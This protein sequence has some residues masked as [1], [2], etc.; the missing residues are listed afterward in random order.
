MTA[1]LALGIDPSPQDGMSIQDCV[2]IHCQVVDA[3]N[4]QFLK[5][6]LAFF[7]AH[8]AIGIQLL[9]DFCNR[10]RQS[11]HVIL[12]GKFGEISTSLAAYL[13]FG[14]RL[15][16]SV[17]LNPFLGAQSL[18]D[19][20]QV[21]AKL[22]GKS[23]YV[24]CATSQSSE[25]P[26]AYIQQ[27][28]QKILLACR[29]AGLGVVIGANRVAEMHDATGLDILAPG[30]GAQGASLAALEYAKTV[31]NEIVFPISRGIFAGGNQSVDACVTAYQ[32]WKGKF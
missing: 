2:H 16:Q 6:N 11:H 4:V 3:V 18:D 5:P 10:Y 7:L 17:T 8:G 20:S 31:P 32:M 27:G 24:L 22:N 29:A 21:C 14:F 30:L 25:G 23:V 19:A 1:C 28:Y 15:A 26:L 12:D 13:H 9:E